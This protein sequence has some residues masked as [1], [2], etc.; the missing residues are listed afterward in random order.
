MIAWLLVPGLVV[1]TS[2][3]LGLLAAKLAG[4]RLGALT[5][6]VGFAGGI[7]LMTLPLELGFSSLFGVIPTALAAAAGL[8]F[9]WRG[10][11]TIGSGWH[12]PAIVG[13]GA[14]AIGMAPLVGSGR[15]GVVGYVLNN[16]PSVHIS[17]VELLSLFGNSTAQAQASSFHAVSGLFDSGYPLGSLM[18]PL[19]VRDMTGVN[20]FYTWSPLIAVM[21]AM[22]AL[23]GY[24]VL[25][26]VDAPRPF[27]AVAATAIAAGY[28]PFSYLTQ[29]G[30]K[31]IAITALLYITAASIF[32]AARSGYGLRA[33]IPAAIAAAA[34][35]DVLGLG[36][37]AWLGPLGLLTGLALWRRM[38]QPFKRTALHTS[39][40][41]LATLLL[42][43][44]SVI[45]SVTFVRINNESLANPAQIGNLQGAVPW[46]EVFNV[47]LDPDYRNASALYAAPTELLV[48]ISALLA[49]VGLVWLMRRQR[50][51]AVPVAF[52][53]FAIGTVY[54]AARYSIYFDAKAYLA[55]APAVGLAT[56][57]GVLAIWRRGGRVRIAAVVAAT[58]LMG[59]LAASDTAVY[60]GSWMTP[61]DRFQ[62]LIDLNER[63]AGSG[64]VLVN[65]RE[66]YVKFLL[67]DLSPWESWGSWQ[68][69]R[70]LEAGPIPDAVPHTPDFD[71]YSS[72]HLARFSRL[73]ERKRPGGSRPPGNYEPIYETEHYRLWERR[74]KPAP[75]FH[76]GIGRL[77]LDGAGELD[78]STDTMK[79]ILVRSNNVRI[80]EPNKKVFPILP[81]DWLRY[82]YG[83]SYSWHP[84]F[85]ERRDATAYAVIEMTLPKGEYSAWLQGSYAGGFRLY[86]N[87]TPLGELFGDL[88]LQD[89]WNRIGQFETDG[90]RQVFV[91]DGLR[92]PIW[93]AGSK[94]SDLVG[95]FGVERIG[96]SERIVTLNGAAAR[97]RYCD[98][99]VDWVE[100]L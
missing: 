14:F 70:G 36:A 93:Q 84:A 100:L 3:G 79:R 37:G 42:S 56:A 73:L 98:E 80:A 59:G 35:V 71:D 33:L 46:R 91:L 38:G 30:G 95:S 48:A 23:S 90:G 61:K 13:L 16:D 9:W 47:W 24:Q 52:V 87:E 29:G 49:L 19:W 54:V 34:A 96:L 26:R 11:R 44:P 99:R 22:L 69:D 15:A 77:S 6:P 21:L 82:P 65:E 28:L 32:L 57:C 86:R 8:V 41:G 55:L 89:A 4:L 83:W 67:R 12:W 60:L 53:S 66:D 81:T 27:S 43:L 94:R 64:P 7:V 78:C 72:D 39:V 45:A 5:I 75:V 62:E 76:A 51:I 18:W 40:W 17:V 2:A 74:S 58:L 20:A 50:R 25:R 31:E 68:P 85:V 1:L 97:K 10:G 92:K 88:G 63:F